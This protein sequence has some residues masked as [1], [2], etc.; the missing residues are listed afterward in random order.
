M[1]IQIYAL[2]DSFSSPDD[3]K[4]KKKNWFGVG[5]SWLKY[6]LLIP[7][8]LL[9]I[10]FVFCLFYK[11]IIICITKCVTEPPTKM[12]MTRLESVDQMYSSI[13]AQ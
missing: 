3:L 6:L 2:S 12:I 8:M 9:T 1:K 10:P 7:P 4:K 13:Y 5:D 11:I